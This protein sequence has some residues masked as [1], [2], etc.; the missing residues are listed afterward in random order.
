[1]S[2]NPKRTIV[3]IFMGAY[4]PGFK[5]GGPVTSIKNMVDR[6]SGKIEF[7]I[8]APDRDL[9][10]DHPYS[11]V[12]KREW[13]ILDKEKV[14]YLPPSVVNVLDVL[15]ALR[16]TQYDVVYLNSF[17]SPRYTIPVLVLRW[18]KLVPKKPVVLAVR[19]EFAPAALDLKSR[20]K[21]VY[22]WFAR[23]F[24]LL[25]DVVFHATNP[26]E[27]ERIQAI[28]GA[29]VQTHLAPPLTKSVCTVE[30]TAVS[31]DGLLRVVFLGRIVPMKNLD[32]ALEILSEVQTPTE[33]T[34]Y[35]PCED[36]EYWVLCQRIIAKLPRHITIKYEGSI[37]PSKVRAILANFDLFFLPT[38][39]ENFGHVIAEALAAGCPVLISD[40]TP[41]KDLEVKMCG[42]AFPLSDRSSFINSI[43]SM[44]NMSYTDRIEMSIRSIAYAKD[45]DSVS[46]ATRL[47]MRLFGVSD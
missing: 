3:L 43:E 31:T 39:G 46:D 26:I 24:G 36:D 23:K 15:V 45:R 27:E 10:S 4:L 47:N 30:R 9:F 40:Q 35:G 19:G 25:N 28:L 32:Y 13:T 17:F 33:F 7:R 14:L 44:A 42:W 1:M 5:G 8:V 16:H 38:R 41:W 21:Q 22:L 6:L 37:H 12:P 20:K 11:D 18:L 29:K 34:V 2:E